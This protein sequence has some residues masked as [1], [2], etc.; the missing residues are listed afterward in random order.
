METSAPV[1]EEKTMTEATPRPEPAAQPVPVGEPVKAAEL[2]APVRGKSMDDAP[3]TQRWFAEE[4]MRRSGFVSRSAVTPGDY[5]RVRI[6]AD[7]DSAAVLIGRRGF[8]VDALEHLVERMSAQALGGHVP[9]NLDINNYRIRQ[10]GHLYGQASEAIDRVRSQGEP[11]HLPPMNP[12]DRRIIHLEVQD[13]EDLET[14]T[15]GEGYDRH[16][17]VTKAGTTPAEE[18]PSVPRETDA[19]PDESTD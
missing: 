19:A 3:E 18:S 11:V 4:L 10:E 1:I 13:L 17:V 9:M 12:R 7:S 16:V 6:T 2:V 8:T 5:N 15:T 14:Y